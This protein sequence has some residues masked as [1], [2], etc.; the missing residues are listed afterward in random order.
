MPLLPFGA[1]QPDTSDY[2]S[3]AKAHNI[4]NVLPRADGYGPFPDF[5]ALSQAL[6]DTCRGGFYALNSDG[7]VTVFAGTSKRLYRANNTDYSWIPVSKTT[8]CTI[9]SASPGVIT[10]TGHDSAVNEPKV[11]S[12]SGG[13]LPAAITAGTVYYVKT[14]LDANT[15]TISATPGGASTRHRPGP[16]RTR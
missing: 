12:N 5:A 13:A 9:S 8:T 16:G 10:E 2:E 7:S 14:V 6:P 15:Y 4:N 1:W 11:F 3:Q